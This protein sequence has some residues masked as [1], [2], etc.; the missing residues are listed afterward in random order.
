MQL[1]VSQNKEDVELLE[2]I[3]RSAMK[4]AGGLEEWLRSL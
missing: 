2:N 1:W 3:Q 4:M